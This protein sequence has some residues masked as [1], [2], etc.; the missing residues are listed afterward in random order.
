MRR[1]R[2]WRRLAGVSCVM[3][4]LGVFF[5]PIGSA[6]GSLNLMPEGPDAVVPPEEEPGAADPAPA[7]QDVQRAERAVSPMLSR[8]DIAR[9]R[10]LLR[11][12]PRAQEFLR[13][14]QFEVKDIG[15]WTD[16]DRLVGASL[17]I[18]FAKAQSFRCRLGPK[19]TTAPR[20]VDR[21]PTR[22]PL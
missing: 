15:P 14:R 21:I 12:D 3:L 8:A 4:G 16:G 11:G 18:G 5:T 7:H 9:A 22:S 19:S 10:R 1:G 2:K 17:I 6:L 20:S 13:G